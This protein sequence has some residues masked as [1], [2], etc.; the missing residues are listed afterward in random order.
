MRA[1]YWRCRS[2]SPI[3]LACLPKPLVRKANGGRTVR[4]RLNHR[5][6]ISFGPDRG[7][8]RSSHGSPLPPFAKWLLGTN[9]QR[10]VCASS[11]R[12]HRGEF[13]MTF[14]YPANCLRFSSRTSSAAATPS[15]RIV[16]TASLPRAGHHV[17]STP[18]DPFPDIR[19]DS[20]LRA[21][22]RRRC[23]RADVWFIGAA[24]RRHRRHLPQ[25]A[26][27]RAAISPASSAN[28][29]VIFPAR[30]A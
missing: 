17:M 3:A 15:R 7:G 16:K 23:H 5:I 13:A 29:T 4:H 26:G 6:I 9:G 24:A 8:Y 21:E 27:H 19:I 1:G 18:G 11:K 20:M 10:Q 30:P 12:A 2:T 25:F 28:L 14:R 22:Y